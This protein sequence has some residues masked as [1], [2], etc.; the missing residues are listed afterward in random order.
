MARISAIYGRSAR[1]APVATVLALSLAALT[2]GA[3]PAVATEKTGKPATGVTNPGFEEG[4]LG[5]ATSGSAASVQGGGHQSAQR[6]THWLEAAGRVTTSQR[7][8][9][10]EGDWVTFSAVV[11]SGGGLASSRLTIKGCGPQAQAS[12]PSTESDDAWLRIAVSARVRGGACSVELTTEGPAGSWA[13]MDDV[14]ISQGRVERAIRGGDLSG[15][16]KNEDFGATYSDA[17]GKLVDPIEHL[18]DEGANLGRLKVWVDPA[19]SYNTVDEVVATAKRIDAAGMKL[20]VDFHY[21]DRWT[22]P[23]AQGMPAAWQGLPAAEVADKVHEHTRTV[24]SALKS[25]GLTADYV[26]VGNEINPGMLWPLGQTWDVVAGD[27][28]EGAQWDNLAMFLTAGARAVREVDASSKVILHLTNINNGIG[29]LTWWFDEATNQGVPFDVI[30]LS[31]YGYWHGSLADLQ[32]A[33]T[34][35]SG[36]YDRDVLVVET[37]YAFTLQD[38]ASAPWENIIRDESQLVAG[39]PATPEAQAANLRAV[40]DVVASAPGGRG[41]GTVYWEPTWTAVAGNGWD[42]ADPA[43]GNAWENQA[44]FDFDGRALPALKEFA[45]DG[46]EPGRSR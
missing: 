15:L 8:A 17:R 29:G 38:D 27:G 21:S 13:G 7:V 46:A 9:A 44:L 1:W 23:G 41:I 30:G 24:L 45:A 28:V 20:L 16:L 19:D 12:V 2:S 10:P 34:T 22:D 43:S 6:L 18:A 11:K 35:L 36:R 25:A 32:N 40:Q 33:V 3:A 31:Y 4:L 14:T 37:A 39:Y 42:P 26:Q 5:W